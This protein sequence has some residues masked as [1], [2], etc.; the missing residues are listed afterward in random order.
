VSNTSRSRDIAFISFGTYMNS[1][2]DVNIKP[3]QRIYYSR[4]GRFSRFMSHVITG[5][6]IIWGLWI[7]YDIYEDP[8]FAPILIFFFPVAVYSIPY[9]YALADTCIITLKG[10]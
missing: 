2:S 7:L 3:T 4:G 1:N 8:S 5:M 9:Y 10:A 6:F